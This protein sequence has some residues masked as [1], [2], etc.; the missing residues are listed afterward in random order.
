M[1]SLGGAVSALSLDKNGAYLLDQ[2][3]SLTLQ[4]VLA[5]PNHRWIPIK[6]ELSLGL[7]T[8]TVW[9]RLP[10]PQP[11]DKNDG[12]EQG[13]GILS[14]SNPLLNK[15]SIYLTKNGKLLSETHMGDHVPITNKRIPVSDLYWLMPHGWQTADYLYIRIQSDSFF[16]SHFRIKSIPTVI[17]D[18]GNQYWMLGLFYGALAIMLL[19]NL[20]VYFQVK[21][22]RYLYYTGYVLSV[23]LFHSMMDG[24]PYYSLSHIYESRLD[25]LS[26]IFVDFA[27]V[28]AV[29]FVSKFLNITDKRLLNAIRTLIITF[30]LA[31]LLEIIEQGHISTLFST[32]MTV[33]NSVSISYLTIKSWMNGNEQA[34]YL[35]LA[36]IVLVASI[37]IY[38]C[39]LTGYLPHNIYTLNSVRFGVVL[40]LAL[41]SFSLAHRINLLRQE[42]LSLQRR[43]NKELGALVKERTQKLE[44]ANQKLQELNET[45]ALTQLKNRAYFT[46][47]I[48][49]EAAR[50]KRSK[51]S[52]A[53]LLT[54][55]DHFKSI[56]DTLGHNAGDYCLRHFARIL[57]GQ[58][59]R[60]TDM[61]C[62]YGG[63]EFVVVLPDTDLD[64]A[65]VVAER[66]RSAVENAKLI[67]EGEPINLTVSIGAYTVTPHA[68]WNSQDW[69]SKA[70]KALYHAKT[71]RNSVAYLAN[72]DK[73]RFAEDT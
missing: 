68:N 51:T 71:K 8:P 36:W 58:M 27:N 24:L 9:V 7:I 60:S 45:D 48:A 57:Q 53:L 46:Q 19:Y 47:F 16:Q 23:G 14:L 18:H 2:Q 66:I 28:F 56:N 49:E 70:D 15:V 39:A 30:F 69:I 50:A 31:M 42:R 62:R 54:D 13:D 12:L 38:V 72:S 44:E 21:D 26:I 1:P 52:I 11:I 61:A 65:L 43:L 22:I 5:A 64:G 41:I 3:G 37:P 4:G 17:V 32:A 6:D 33:V 55:L 25:R 29:L 40:E 10:I 59:P 73:P 34:R 35:A 20:F 67:F 63:E